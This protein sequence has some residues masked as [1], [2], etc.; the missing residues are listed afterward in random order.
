MRNSVIGLATAGALA[1][2][3][4]GLASPALAATQYVG[5]TQ[6]A[7]YS[8]SDGQASAFQPVDCSV[9]VNHQ[10]TDV[11]VQWC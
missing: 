10:G 8:T 2:L 9:H 3:T 1:A 5:P 11:N 4:I 6:H 7:V